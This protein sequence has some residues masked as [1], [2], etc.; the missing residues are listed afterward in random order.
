MYAMADIFTKYEKIAVER[1]H[2]F[3]DTRKRAVLKMKR[4]QVFRI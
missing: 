1:E 3:K 2:K 4:K